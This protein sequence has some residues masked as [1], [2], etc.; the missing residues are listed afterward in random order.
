LCSEPVKATMRQLHMY[1][2]RKKSRKYGLQGN[3]YNCRELR[4]R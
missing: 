1:D 4:K 2:G 3:S